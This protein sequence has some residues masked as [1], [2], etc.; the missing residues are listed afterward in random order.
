MES[1]KFGQIFFESTRGRIVSLLRCG[2]SSVEELSQQLELTDNAVRSHLATLE[3]DGLI[4]RGGV[5]AGARKPQVAYQLTDEERHLFPKAYQALFNQLLTILKLRLAP[6]ELSEILRE[7][8][9]GLAADRTPKEANESVESRTERA[10]K[11]M[12]ELG[13]VAIPVKAED[14]LLLQSGSGCPFS[15]SVAQHPEVCRLAETLLS[16]ITGFEVREHCTRG[17]SPRCAFEIIADN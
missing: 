11:V 6:D 12:E 13:G 1:T 5:I 17:K 2:T 15:D 16:E 14:K 4:E 3:R 10:V 9:R 7:V 8:A